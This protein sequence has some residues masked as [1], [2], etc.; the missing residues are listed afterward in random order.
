MG[1][2]QDCNHFVLICIKSPVN[3]IQTTSKVWQRFSKVMFEVSLHF[4]FTFTEV[5]LDNVYSVYYS[6]EICSL[7]QSD[8]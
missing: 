6:D 2:T 8:I 7:C 3:Q 1:G 4:F 5:V